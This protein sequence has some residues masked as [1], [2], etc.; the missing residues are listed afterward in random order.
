MFGIS[1]QEFQTK[2]V[3]PPHIYVNHYSYFLKL[4]LALPADSWSNKQSLSNL[5][6]LALKLDPLYAKGIT[7]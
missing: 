7:A 4:F 5:G 3:Y 6:Y 1:M 2:I